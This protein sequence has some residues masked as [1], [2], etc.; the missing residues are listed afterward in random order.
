[1]KTTW[2]SSAIIRSWYG[3]IVEITKA[4]RPRLFMRTNKGVRRPTPKSYSDRPRMT[5]IPILAPDYNKFARLL[6]YHQAAELRAMLFALHSNFNEGT[7]PITSD[8][9]LVVLDS[10]CTCAITFD[11]DDFVGQIRPVQDVEL[12]GISSGLRVE[13]VGQVNWTFLN[14]FGHRTTIPLTCLYV[15]EATTRLL[16]PQQLSTRHGASN[17]NGSWVGYGNDALVFYEGH[18]IKFPY[19]EGSNLPVAKLAPGISKFKAF[20]V[21][22]TTP[23]STATPRN[24]NLS[25]ASRKLLRIHHRLGHKGFHELQKWAAEGTNN[26]PRELANCPIPMCCA[27]QY[28]AAKK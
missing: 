13:G 26:M 23:S 16:P 28:G 19:H 10:G 4:A 1:M 9:M 14:E 12:Q 11:K 24:D 15:P 3:S 6:P 22:T 7:A 8:D 25:S 20:H 18:C 2:G 21:S 17:A 5:E 27:C